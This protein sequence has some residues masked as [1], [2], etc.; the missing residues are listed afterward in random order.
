MPIQ[1]ILAVAA[2]NECIRET[3]FSPLVQTEKLMLNMRKKRVNFF[4]PLGRLI[5]I[6]NRALVEAGRYY[7]AKAKM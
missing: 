1:S 5:L 7:C 4:S 2:G 6:N 3:R